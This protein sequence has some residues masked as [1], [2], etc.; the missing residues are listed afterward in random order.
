MAYS[1]C[2]GVCTIEGGDCRRIG[3]WTDG[4]S[5]RVY[6]GEG[7]A[8]VADDTAGIGIGIG[9]PSC[10]LEVRSDGKVGVGRQIK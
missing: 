5:M 3:I 7:A 2:D 6:I 8:S 1:I 4:P 9:T 10:R